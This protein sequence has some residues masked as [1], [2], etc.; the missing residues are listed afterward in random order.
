MTPSAAGVAYS[1]LTTDYAF[2]C[3]NLAAADAALRQSPEPA[4]GYLFAQPPFADLYGRPPD[5]VSD[6]GACSPSQIPPNVC[7]GAEL[8]YVF[9]TLD[10]IATARDRPRPDD[11]A[12]AQSMN[13]A[14]F[15][16]RRQS[17][18]P[19]RSMDDV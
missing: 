13:A 5:T 9:D 6:Y 17:P 19:W 14:W 4:F 15:A 2:V 8:P 1:N 10:V 16:F 7:H 12:L 3:G 11:R 18:R